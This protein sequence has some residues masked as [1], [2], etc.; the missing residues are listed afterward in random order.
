[1]HRPWIVAGTS[2]PWKTKFPS[3]TTWLPP[4]NAVTAPAIPTSAPATAPL[5]SVTPRGRGDEAT[6]R[7]AEIHP[8]IPSGCAGR[9]VAGVAGEARGEAGPKL[10]VVHHVGVDRPDHLDRGRTRVAHHR[11]RRLIVRQRERMQRAPIGVVE[12]SMV[13]AWHPPWQLHAVLQDVFQPTV[14]DDVGEQVVQFFGNPLKAGRSGASGGSDRYQ[15]AA[16][17]PESSDA[18]Q[19]R[20]GTKHGYSASEGGE[21]NPGWLCMSSPTSR[22]WCSSRPSTRRIC[23]SP[24][25][26]TALRERPQAHSAMPPQPAST[27]QGC[28]SSSGHRSGGS[29]RRIGCLVSIHQGEHTDGFRKLS[30]PGCLLAICPAKFISMIA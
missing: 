28:S 24:L 14:V 8:R 10:V 3:E 17:R 27:Q 2:K 29:G 11:S 19:Y 6:P 4:P 26:S 5:M 20:G 16:N 7:A 9:R 30:C 12:P 21:T 15:R 13:A 22:L 1:M 18:T 25:A 23:P